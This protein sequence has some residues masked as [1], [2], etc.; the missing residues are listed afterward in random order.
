M[1]KTMLSACYQELSKVLSVHLESL[2]AAQCV[3]Q[4]RFDWRPEAVHTLLLAESH[5]LTPDSELQTMRGS[6]HA[7]TERP[8]NQTFAR[9]VYC[10]GYGEHE[11]AGPAL[12]PT[13]GTWQFWQLFASCVRTPGP[14]TFAPLQKGSN[15][16]FATRI[17]AKLSVLEE[18]LALGIWLVDASPV[19]LCSPGGARLHQSEYGQILRCSWHNYVEKLVRDAKPHSIVVIGKDVAQ[20]LHGQL[21]RL[22]NVEIHNVRQPQGCRQPGALDEVHATLNRACHAAAR[23]RGA[24]KANHFSVP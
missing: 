16:S 8:L 12:P 9:F 1:G 3:E 4:H 19:A 24:I 17:G 18:M 6:P 21:S 15:P 13:A 11:F 14:R 10:L 7:V 5:L 20:A 23:A 22:H 2:A